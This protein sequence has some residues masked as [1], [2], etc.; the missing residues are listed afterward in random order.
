MKL[1]YERELMAIVLAIQKWK[2]YLLDQKFVVHT[3]QRSV[4]FLLDERDVYLD[5]HKWLIDG[6][7][8]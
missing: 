3:N 6:I 5:Y 1:I 7:R 8:F 2:H 4:K